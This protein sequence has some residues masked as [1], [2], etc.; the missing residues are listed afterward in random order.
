MQIK[1]SPSAISVFRDCPRCF[2]LEKNRN[3]KRPR[4]IFPSLPGGMDRIIKAYMDG[5]RPQHYK[6]SVLPPELVHPRTSGLALFNDQTKL[7]RW[8]NWRSGLVY[9]NENGDILSGALDDLLFDPAAGLYHPFDY[10]TKGSPTTDEDT[11]KYYQPQTDFYGVMLDANG[12]PVGD[13]AIFSYWS[14][15]VVLKYAAEGEHAGVVSF[16]TQVIAIDVNLERGKELFE[17]ALVCLRGPM[18]E[19]DP[20]CEYCH[21]FEQRGRHAGAAA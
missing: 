21:H 12:M 4:G 17:R 18:P 13:R 2:W 1:L 9:Q 14:P 7:N 3:V 20:E 8:R 10:K 11:I 5:C 15:D 6:G 16:N 19:A